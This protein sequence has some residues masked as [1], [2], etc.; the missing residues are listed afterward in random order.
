MAYNLKMLREAEMYIQSEKS[1]PFLRNRVYSHLRNG[2]A[3][4]DQSYSAAYEEVE[5]TYGEHVV[6]VRKFTSRTRP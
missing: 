6:I 1:D 5:E 4:L 3:T 2:I